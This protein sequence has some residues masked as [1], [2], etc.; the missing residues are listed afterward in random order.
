MKI[1]K[2]DHICIA[3]KDLAVAQKLWEPVLGKSG[4]D[5]TYTDEAAKVRVVRYM[6]GEVGLELLEDTT[7]DGPTAR[8]IQTRGEGI[9]LIGL[10]VP[11]TAEAIAELEA[12]GYPI[13]SDPEHGKVLPSPLGCDYGFVHPKGLNG[14]LVEVIDYKWDE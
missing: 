5:E 2:I 10:N 8:S 4:P 13:I 9:T 1:N 11:N 12:K 3:V 14:V 7:G 6:V